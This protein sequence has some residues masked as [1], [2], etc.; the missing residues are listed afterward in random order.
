MAP[1]KA[2]ASKKV[3]VADKTK[4]SIEAGTEAKPTEIEIIVRPRRGNCFSISSTRYN[5]KYLAD[6]G[7]NSGMSHA[8]CRQPRRQGRRCRLLAYTPRM[9]RG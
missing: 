2:R 5:M 1:G 6:T 9:G 4:P 8:V 3:K 7:L